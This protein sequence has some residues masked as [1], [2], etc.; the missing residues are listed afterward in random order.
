MRTNNKTKIVEKWS[1]ESE[2][3]S[4]R[5][6]KKKKQTSSGKIRGRRE[7]QV[8]VGDDRWGQ[9]GSGK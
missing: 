5:I 1:A 9:S 4:K 8:E 6:D 3:G 7:G 2:E